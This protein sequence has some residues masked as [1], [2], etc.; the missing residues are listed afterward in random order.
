M[1][2]Q[3][4]A[5][6]PLLYALVP[7]A[8]RKA[9]GARGKRIT[10]LHDG[11]FDS[12]AWGWQ[13]SE[14]ASLDKTVSRA[15]GGSLRV[16]SANGDYARFL[17]F[18]PREGAKYTVTGWMKTAGVKPLTA[19]G[20]AF[21]AAPQFEFQGRPAQYT[22]DGHIEE[23]HLGNTAGDSDWTR[24]SQTFTCRTGTTWFEVA[25]GLYRAAGTA[26]FDDVTFVE[27]ERPAELAE[28]VEPDLAAQWA[29]AAVLELTGKRKPKAAILRDTL[30]VRGAAS[31]PARLAELLRDSYQ[32]EYVTASD[33]AR[34][35]R[36]DR[37][38]FD[39]LVL[40]YGESFPA[41]ARMR[42]G[43]FLKQGGSLFTTGGYAFQSPV[44]T[45]GEGWIF[46]DEHVA[47]EHGENLI[48]S[49]D[50]TLGLAALKAAGWTVPDGADIREKAARVSI[51]AGVWGRT[52][53]WRYSFPT[54]GIWKR[55]WFEARIRAEAIDTTQ[56][57]Y[58]FLN[59]EQL[60]AAGGVVYAT[61]QEVGRATG[62]S[63]WQTVRMV[64]SLAAETRRLR[65][66][67]GLR[68][69]TGSLWVSGLRLEQRSDDPQINTSRGLPQ[70]DLVIEPEQ[71][72]M[73][74]ADYR[75]K[76]VSY[77]EAAPNQQVCETA[78]RVHGEFSGYAASGVL[79]INHSRWIPL[80][81]AY[82]RYG[83]LRGAAAALMHHYDGEFARGS[84][85][86]FGVDSA[87]LFSGGKLE[88]CVPGIARAL[89]RNC[90]LHELETDFA[91]YRDGEPVRLR[92]KA[93]NYGTA[94]QRVQVTLEA[95]PVDAALPAYRTTQAWLLAPGETAATIAEWKPAQFA[96]SQYRVE[97]RLEIGTE[98][99]DRVETGFEVWKDAT[100]RAGTPI[101]FRD[102]YV[103]LHGRP[104]FLQGTDDYCY[105]FLNRNENPLTWQNDAYC[106][107]DSCVDLYENLMG[108]RGPQQ[109]PPRTWW[110]WIDAMLLA[111]QR[112]GGIF[113]PGMLIFS[114]TAVSD[115]DLEEQKNF[116]RQFA[117]RYR[118]AP[119]LVYYLN[120]DLELHD[121]NL[122]DIQKLYHAYLRQKYGS[123]EALKRAWT[124]SP[125]ET[126]ID[127]LKIARGADNFRDVRRLD[128]YQFRVQLVLRWLNGLSQAIRKIDDRHP[129]TAEFYQSS[130]S[131]IDLVS[132]SGDLTF[133][134]FGY[135]GD[136]LTDR[137]RFAAVLK[138]LDL[139][140]HGRGAHVGEF[141]VKTHP[142]WNTATGYIQARSE[143]YEQNYFLE[144]TH[145]AFGQGA[146]KVQ[147]WSWKY[148]AD[149]P[150]EWGMHYP[151]DG[152]PRDVLAYYRNA[153][154]L[155]RYFRPRYEA[156]PVVVLLPD[157]SRKGGLGGQVHEGLL[158]AL[159]LLIDARVEFGTLDDRSL[160]KLPPGTKAIF[161]P[162][163]Y[164]PSDETVTRLLAFVRAG[165]CLYLSGDI[166]Y[167]SLRQ[168]TRTA[169]LEELCGVV[170]EEQLYSGLSFRTALAAA[171]PQAGSRWPE[172]RAAPGIR[173]RATQA[174]VL[175]A[176][177]SGVPVV[178]EFAL[179]E[180]R[181][182]FTSDPFELH[183]AEPNPDGARFYAALL[184][185]MGVA[186]NR[187]EPAG[188]SLHAYQVPAEDGETVH[189]AMNYGDVDLEKVTLFPAGKTLS[190]GLPAHRP[191][192][193]ATNASG[194]AI[195][196][197]CAGEARH[198]DELLL[199]AASHLMAI[200][201]DRLPLRESRRLLILPMGTGEVEVPNAARWHDARAFVG[202]VE[203][204]RWK[205]YESVRPNSKD[206]SLHFNVDAERNLS[207]VM[208]GESN[209]ERTLGALAET[210]VLRPWEL[211]R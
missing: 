153:G 180:G 90:Y 62:T 194:H 76:R 46:D 171:L 120:G 105:M 4:T 13:L 162:L 164:C 204:G 143:A 147:N 187:V 167:D 193:A 191:G 133:A 37:R 202:A 183:V 87:D 60:D 61:Q 196:I 31:D 174:K 64:V 151:C 118:G 125:P 85:V 161:Y 39:L 186:G 150:F 176:T 56:G 119:G 47:L 140:L 54:A 77:L 142:G 26:W 200:A 131:G 12:D 71:I 166:S 74:D 156:P 27:D 69:A 103:Q 28:V 66:R 99:V 182:I 1:F 175:A 145:T 165:G 45:N 207:M 73:F 72:G 5:A 139:R 98:T 152:V 30:P 97:A 43:E 173:V 53:D 137:R 179:G 132:A 178:T 114:N 52:V 9:A 136:N 104:V 84:W 11:G 201:G 23:Q 68:Q 160:D 7:E 17:V 205:T 154:L 197:E 48:P 51:P 127:Q 109:N 177:A 83:R 122:P 128:D 163:A 94:A 91:C 2:L 92:V 159:R 172:H 10:L 34:P 80:V 88:Q 185:R 22:A 81:N 149:L 130:N 181:V 102:N 70:D 123:E 89:A 35:E 108:L 20:G 115:A 82:D 58:G 129:I 49:G 190:F 95:I 33:L 75:L 93:S 198:G 195:A 124:V 15:G 78:S 158:E 146:A 189:V 141:G 14:G 29:H 148:P 59:L 101:G 16:Q 157:E 65:V 24:F 203:R 18:N 25:V 107:R 112:A 86:F 209:E 42:L 40:P 32:T 134:N 188:A 192:V 111:V 168:R 126:A 67:F 106:C 36:F 113:M 8:S 210:W 170:F 206:G 169:R 121:P 116:C 211:G 63:D 50:F 96:H 155:F 208:L 100:L 110:R 138:F 57:G 144:L 79:G 199:R 19:G 41:P 117:E 38:V 3:Q 6:S 135:F 55:Y 184:E 21:F 44:V